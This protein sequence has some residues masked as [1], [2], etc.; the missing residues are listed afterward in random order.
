MGFDP[1]RPQRKTPFDYVFVAGAILAGVALLLWA[2][3]G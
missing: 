2:F 3:F 1:N